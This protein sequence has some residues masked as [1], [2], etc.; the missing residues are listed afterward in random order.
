MKKLLITFLI[1]ATGLFTT[2]CNKENM[3]N[4]EKNVKTAQTESTYVYPYDAWAPTFQ[5]CWNE[6]IKLVGTEKIEYVGG[7]PLF[8][9][10]LNKQLFT[11]D[12]LS[13]DSYYISVT[14]Q[15]LQHKKEIEKAIKDKFNEKSDILDKFTFDN[16]KDNETNKWFIYSILL[17][18]FKFIKPY[19]IIDSQYFNHDSTRKYKYFGY[20][21][22]KHDAENQWIREKNTESLFYINDNDFAVKFTDKDDK[23][24]MIIYLTSSDKSFIDV[25]DELLKKNAK[26]DEY[27]QNRIKEAKKLYK[28][29]VDITFKNYYKIP[30]MHIDKELNF[31]EELANKEIKGKLFNE[32]GETWTI[33]KTL[34]TIKFDMDNE[35]AKLKSEAAIS[36]KLNA[37]M[38]LRRD[39]II[40]N[41]YYFDRPFV[42]FLKEKGKDKP[43]FAAR[44]KDG[45]FLVKE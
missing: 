29:D 2:G 25:Y 40:N 18:N 9:D 13:E 37:I 11:K 15:T 3:E 39:I 45:E 16:V 28:E 12:D 14:K 17:K 8:A 21:N 36:T 20:L 41:L 26:K 24:E 35:G 22:S 23:E 5:L 33:L 31:D 30:F 4:P 19:A 34:Q 10:E 7:N 44:V 6:F 32:T 1:L 38:P 27:T 43:Y 42:I